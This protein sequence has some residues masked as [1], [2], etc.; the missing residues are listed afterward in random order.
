VQ[1]WAKEVTSGKVRSYYNHI[2]SRSSCW[3]FV[4]LTYCGQDSCSMSPAATDEIRSCRNNCCVDQLR[5][6]AVANWDFRRYP[7]H[8]FPFPSHRAHPPHHLF[9]LVNS[10]K[11]KDLLAAT[12]CLFMM[13]GKYPS[14]NVL[15]F[16]PLLYLE[17]LFLGFYAF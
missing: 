12:V 16:G 4:C 10:D 2:F 9:M 5:V 7:H 15:M 3:P 8:R 1:N 13:F 11:F 14:H 6:I 17:F